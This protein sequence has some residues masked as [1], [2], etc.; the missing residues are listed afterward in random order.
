MPSSLSVH[1]LGLQ[2][3]V[4]LT[5][6]ETDDILTLLKT[7]QDEPIPHV[8]FR[9]AWEQRSSN[10]GSALMI[11]MTALEVGV[12]SLIATLIPHASW[13]A[14]QVPTPPLVQILTEYL[15]KL[16]A[17]LFFNNEVKA[18]PPVIL[19][20]IRKGVNLRNGLTHRGQRP[21]DFEAL[22]S[23]LLAIKDCLWLFDYYAGHIWAS[24]FIR[25]ETLHALCPSSANSDGGAKG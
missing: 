2:Q 7:D 15:P 13:L 14:M 17:R 3:T 24:E 1:I 22:E 9:E 16:P 8:L 6:N 25:R 12:K 10:Q 19:E 18:P 4:H 23:L 21:P 11:G 20:E 5:P